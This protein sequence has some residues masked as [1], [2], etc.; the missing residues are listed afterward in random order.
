VFIQ[1]THFLDFGKR[2]ACEIAQ[3]EEAREG[4]ASLPAGTEQDDS[5]DE[6]V[7]Q[8]LI[9]IGVQ[10]QSP[11]DVDRTSLFSFANA[12][13]SEYS[14]GERHAVACCLSAPPLARVLALPAE[15]DTTAAVDGI[16]ESLRHQ[17]LDAFLVPAVLDCLALLAQRSFMERAD[18]V[19]VLPHI[20]RQDVRSL[21]IK[22]AQ[23]I[24][25]PNPLRQ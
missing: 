16:V 9:R 4:L 24:G 2:W 6:L 8:T 14:P 7:E 10:R 15:P 1:R 17:R 22:G 5:I 20:R 18:V 21:F 19:R 3:W 13:S 25:R 12:G 23:I 11:N